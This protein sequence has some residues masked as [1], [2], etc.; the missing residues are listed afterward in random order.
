MS[1]IRLLTTEEKSRLKDVFENEFDGSVIPEYV[2]GIVEAGEVQ[3]FI[4]VENL[5]RVGLIWAK[6]SLRGSTKAATNS[7]ALVKYV[8]QAIPAG[9]SVIVI[10]SDERF[11]SLLKKLGMSELEGKVFRRDF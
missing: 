1:E 3:S 4:V 6:E 7:S 11:E 8:H 2:V 9:K 5:I 10:A